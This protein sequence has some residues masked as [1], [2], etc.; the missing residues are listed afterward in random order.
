[1]TS[2][3]SSDSNCQKSNMSNRVEIACRLFIP[4][5]KS[6]L[7]GCLES[8]VVAFALCSQRIDRL[9]RNGVTLNGK[10]VIVRQGHILGATGSLEAFM[11]TSVVAGTVMQMR[12]TLERT[13]IFLTGSPVVR[14]FTISVHSQSGFTDGGS[15]GKLCRIFGISLVDRN[16]TISVVSIMNEVVDCFHIIGFVCNECAFFNRKVFIGFPEDIRC[17]CRIG[18]ICGS[19]KL[20]NRKTGNAILRQKQV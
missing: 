1:M 20:R 16:H 7:R 12:G 11:E 13:A 19:C 17:N 4:Y 2:D 14:E 15:T 10:S 8:G 5:P 3:K 9:K 6:F 18:H